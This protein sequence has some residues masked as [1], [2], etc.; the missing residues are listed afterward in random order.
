[1]DQMMVR[2]DD[3]VHVGDEVEIFGPHISL[4]SMAKDLNTISY[5]IMCLVSNR[6][7]RIYMQT[8][9][10]KKIVEFK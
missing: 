3:R 4:E 7:P 10:I 2:V 8:G 9:S 1:M 6:V 5:E